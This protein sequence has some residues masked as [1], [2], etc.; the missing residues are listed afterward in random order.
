MQLSSRWSSPAAR[1][2]RARRGGARGGGG[3]RS[4]AFTALY[5]ARLVT[6]LLPGS[7]QA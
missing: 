6:I 4:R 7:S 3:G 5:H 2:R 1:G